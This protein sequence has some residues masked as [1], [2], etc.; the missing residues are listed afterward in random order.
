MVKSKAIAKA[1]KT[2]TVKQLDRDYA[3]GWAKV[4]QIPRKG[5]Y[6]GKK[7]KIYTGGGF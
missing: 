4:S 7:T 1:L 2:R 6:K 5:K 3:V